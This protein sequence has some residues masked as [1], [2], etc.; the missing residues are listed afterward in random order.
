MRLAFLSSRLP[1]LEFVEMFVDAVL[2]KPTLFK[3]A[4]KRLLHHLFIDEID[5]AGMRRDASLNSNDER[6]KPKP[7]FLL[8]EMTVDNHKGIVVLAATKSP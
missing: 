2:Q 6:S 3:Q 4:M 5:A 7:A 8:S 1:A